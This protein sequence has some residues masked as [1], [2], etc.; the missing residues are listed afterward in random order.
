LC[1]VLLTHL[2]LLTK[3]AKS[4]ENAGVDMVMFCANTLHKVYD[5]VEKK[6]NTPNTEEIRVLLKN[7]KVI[8][9][10]EAQ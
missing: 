2:K 7:K 5:I 3:A 9:I 6:I 4:L 8:F 10:D 1:P